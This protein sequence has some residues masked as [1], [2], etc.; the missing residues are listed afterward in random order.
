MLIEIKTGR[1]TTKFLVVVQKIV[2][3]K[4]HLKI[5]EYDEIIIDTICSYRKY[6]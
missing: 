4:L 5:K 1:T 6:K 2:D 3:D